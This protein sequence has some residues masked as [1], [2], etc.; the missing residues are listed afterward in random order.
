MQKKLIALAI[1]AAFSAPA[2]ADTTIYGV[3]DA[4]WG[5]VSNSPEVGKKV[6]ESGVAFSQN[7]TSRIG[8]KQTEDLGGGM[9]AIYQL[10]MGLSSNPGS[11][12]KFGTVPTSLGGSGFAPNSSI[13]PDRVMSAALVLGQGTTLVAGRVSSPLRNIVYGYDA[14]Y[15]S[16]L[17]GNLVTMD[18]N[19]TARAV[20]LAAVQDFGAV[21][22]TLAVLN[23]TTKVDGSGDTQ[24][25]NGAEVTANFKQD[26]LS[27]AAGYRSTKATTGALGGG[28][29][30]DSTTKVMIVAAS[31]D[32]GVAKLYG[33]YGSVTVDNAITSTS[34]KKTYESVGVNV[35]FT[36]TFAGYVQLGTGKHDNGVTNP[37]YTASAVGV[38]YDLSKTTAL[39]GHYGTAKED[40]VG[41]VD[42]I[43]FGLLHTF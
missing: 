16:N 5:T 43:A 14:Q 8:F 37:K 22:G 9:K 19:L 40:T 29:S 27:V 38:K 12:A 11:D 42:Q 20:A 3:M 32:F 41:K 13:S 17:I 6:T 26:A 23:H 39:Y 10:E 25:C 36:S 33:Q 1:A 2:F 35:P 18:A 24:L 30:A 15:G 34:D 31:Y 21:T 28:S 4:G 7:Q